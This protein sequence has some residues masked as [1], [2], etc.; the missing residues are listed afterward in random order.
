MKSNRRVI[1]IDLG[2]TNVRGGMVDEQGNLLATSQVPIRAEEGVEQGLVRII[3][4]I[5]KIAQDSSVS[6]LDGIGIGATGPVD[7]V[8]GTIQNPYTLPGWECVPIVARLQEHFHL[9]V[10]LEN[11]A[12]VAALGE[13][14]L[15]A[16]KG[17]K[18][19]Y[20]VTIG[21]GVGTACILDGQ[22]YRGLGG[23]H[24][25]GG[26]HIL[27]PSGPPCY[28]GANGCWESLAS[29]TAIASQAQEETKEDHSSLLWKMTQGDPEQIDARMVA[30][31]AMQNDPLARSVIER[32]A[33]Y[34]SLG[35]VNIVTLFTP[36][37]I[38]L[39]GGVMKSLDL[40]MPAIQEA[41][42]V[43]NVMVPAAKVII[44][45]A[46]LGY[47]AGLYGAAYTVLNN[48]GENHGRYRTPIHNHLRT[49]S[50]R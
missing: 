3:T 47:L 6:R 12:D 10:T 14:W 18:R 23:A 29:G 35:I 43:H 13:Y 38:V 48:L 36:E 50:G 37:M 17:V 49:Q 34:I 21:T 22:I 15:G 28:C 31:A 45:P 5:E 44:R 25:D 19:L 27:D 26:H 30:E 41:M 40:F 2:G 7:P 42:Q 9:P 39:S 46:A 16:G 1:G 4:L 20:A 24:P 11:D 33:R 8:E 32:A